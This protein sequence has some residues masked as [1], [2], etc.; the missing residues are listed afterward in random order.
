MFNEKLRIKVSFQL[1]K[2]C[3]CPSFLVSFFYYC[4]RVRKYFFLFLFP[5]KI[6]Q[7]ISMQLYLVPLKIK[8]KVYRGNWKNLF[9]KTLV[10]WEKRKKFENIKRK[11]A[12]IYE[13][14]IYPKFNL[15]KVTYFIIC[16]KKAQALKNCLKS[17]C[18]EN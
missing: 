15:V 4:I 18:R 11:F 16:E 5:E 7:S 1:V 3:P 17:K 13:K 6:F 9:I 8:F 12:W 2:Y 14:S 10:F